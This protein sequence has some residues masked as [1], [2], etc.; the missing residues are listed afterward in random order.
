[1]PDLAGTDDTG[2]LAVEVEPHK[3]IEGKVQLAYAVERAMDLPVQCEQQRN[4]MFGD[5]MR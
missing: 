2:S 4:S 1:L 5:G 3:S